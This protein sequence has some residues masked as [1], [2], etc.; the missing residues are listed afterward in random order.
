MNSKDQILNKLKKRGISDTVEF[1]SVISDKRIFKDY[2]EYSS[3]IEL[4]IENF[5]KLSGEIFVS[6]NLEEA[7]DHL[8]NIISSL[9]NQSCLTHDSET[10]IKLLDCNPKLEDFFEIL[11]KNKL[12]SAKFA[13]YE[14]G[15]TSADFLIA[16]TGS[17]VVNSLS[18][19]G[20]RL[21]VLPPIHIVLA[22]TKQIVPSL[23]DIIRSDYVSKHWSYA[24]IISGPSRTSD[25]EKQ[26][27]LGAHGP[28]RVIVI[29]IENI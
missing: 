17:I 23:D 8:I 24:T 10:V 20:R 21:S 1:P 26:L 19:G 5:G 3:L 28:K 7:S 4:F 27:V 11:S 6:K 29:L 2:P 14:V 15:L 22:E 13:R 9:D 12:D 18:S 25:I 16:R